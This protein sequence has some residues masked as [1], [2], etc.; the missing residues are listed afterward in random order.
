M[1]L[2]WDLFDKITILYLDNFVTM[3]RPII[4]TAPPFLRL[5]NKSHGYCRML[6]AP[7]DAALQTSLC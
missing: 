2:E 4:I 7:G 3:W 6:L 1:V 5:G